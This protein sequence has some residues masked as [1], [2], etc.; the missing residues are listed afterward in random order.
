MVNAIVTILCKEKT[1]GIDLPT[2]R[3]VLCCVLVHIE[4]FDIELQSDLMFGLILP[5][6]LN[7]ENGFYL[8]L[9]SFSLHLLKNIWHRGTESQTFFDLNQPPSAMLLV[10]VPNPKDG[11]K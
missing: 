2:F 8:N 4:A 1:R 10:L 7:S 6:I 5:S 11:G 3:S 9:H